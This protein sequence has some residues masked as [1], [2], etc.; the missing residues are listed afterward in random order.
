MTAQYSR[1]NHHN[2]NT[3]KHSSPKTTQRIFF[4]HIALLD[5]NDESVSIYK[6]SQTMKKKIYSPE[7]IFE[8][9]ENSIWKMMPNDVY[10]VNPDDSKFLID[11]STWVKKDL[12]Y[13]IPFNHV[14]VNSFKCVY[15]LSPKSMVECVIEKNEQGEIIDF[16]METEFSINVKGVKEDILTFLCAL[17]F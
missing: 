3:N 15:K 11:K 16:Y 10:V 9:R 13:Q 12:W 8:I 1:V 2:H 14:C 7:G 17:K 6:T 5:V 4:P